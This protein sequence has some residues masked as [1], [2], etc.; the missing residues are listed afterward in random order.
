LGGLPRNSCSESVTDQ[1]LCE[2]IKPD[3][4]TEILKSLSEEFHQIFTGYTYTFFMKITL[5]VKPCLSETL[6]Y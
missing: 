1:Y 3:F 4:L 6:A 5:P 2:M